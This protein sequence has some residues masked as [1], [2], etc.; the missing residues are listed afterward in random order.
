MKDYGKLLKEVKNQTIRR[1]MLIL[2]TLQDK[3]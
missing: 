3:V 1:T 2:E